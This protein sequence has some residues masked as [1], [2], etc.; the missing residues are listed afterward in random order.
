MSMAAWHS[1]GLISQACQVGVGAGGEQPCAGR[2]RSARA[3]VP[4]K[5]AQVKRT[6]DRSAKVA[7]SLTIRPR[8][9][10]VTKVS[11]TTSE[12]RIWAFQA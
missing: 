4:R 11:L 6:K 1:I 5:P 3:V 2:R 7:R 10:T 8:S 9:E 12:R